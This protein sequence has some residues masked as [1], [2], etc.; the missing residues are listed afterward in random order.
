[1]ES[2]NREVLTFSIRVKSKRG[3]EFRRWVNSVLKQYILQGYAINQRRIQQLGEVI[4]I[5]KCT[6]NEANICLAKIL[7]CLQLHFFYKLRLL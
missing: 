1:M 5:M 6:E 4:R 7:F 2:Q 3:V